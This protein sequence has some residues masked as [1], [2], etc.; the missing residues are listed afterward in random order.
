MTPLPINTKVVLLPIQPNA[1]FHTQLTKVRKNYYSYYNHH[2]S[3][4]STILLNYASCTP[5]QSESIAYIFTF[6]Y[7]RAH[8]SDVRIGT[9]ETTCLFFFFRILVDFY[10]SFFFFFSH[11]GSVTRRRGR[12]RRSSLQSPNLQFQPSP[13]RLLLFL[14]SIYRPSDSSIRVQYRCL[15][16]SSKTT[17]LRTLTSATSLDSHLALAPGAQPHLPAP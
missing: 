1:L 3:R 8:L 17:A 6:T 9:R 14:G 4:N 15:S 16:V 10:C 12:G 13:Q 2:N 5:S 11:H 7:P